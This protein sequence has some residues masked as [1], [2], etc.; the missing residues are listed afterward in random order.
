MLWFWNVKCLTAHQGCSI[1]VPAPRCAPHVMLTYTFLFHVTNQTEPA[2]KYSGKCL[3][4]IFFF[5]VMVWV[6]HG[7][8]CGWGCSSWLHACE[9][10]WQMGRLRTCAASLSTAVTQWLTC[11]YLSIRIACVLRWTD[12]SGCRFTSGH[13]LINGW[14]VLGLVKAQGTPLCPHF[15]ACPRL[16][17]GTLV[18]GWPL[19]SA[20][21]ISSSPWGSS[22]HPPTTSVSH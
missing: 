13:F 21:S 22:N 16:W 4:C 18:W 7:T 8:S 11:T 3:K 9:T 1:Q 20:P 2:K 10:C 5:H 15:C 6:S 17:E 12:D 14:T 19:A